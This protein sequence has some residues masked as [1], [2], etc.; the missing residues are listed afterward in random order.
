MNL[1]QMRMIRNLVIGYV[2][3]LGAI[4]VLTD[5]SIVRDLVLVLYGGAGL[6]LTIAYA[7]P[8]DTSDPGGQYFTSVVLI[9]LWPVCVAL[10][11]ICNTLAVGERIWV[12]IQERRK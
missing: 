2:V 5:G 1:R 12:W 8:E 11:A 7:P 6:G 9:V 10:W 4:I 3:V